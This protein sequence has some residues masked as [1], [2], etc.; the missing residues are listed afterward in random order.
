MSVVL[1]A[2]TAKGAAILTSDAGRRNWQRRFELKGWNVTASARDDQGRYYVAVTGPVFGPALFF[3]DDLENWTQLEAAPR[4]EPGNKANALHRR[5]TAGAVDPMGEGDDEARR[6]EQIWTL[7]AANGKLYAGVSEAGL[8][9]SE[10]RGRSWEPVRGLN[11]HESREHWM[12]GA[13]GLCAHTVLTDPANP[14]RMWVGISAAGFFRSDDGGKTWAAKNDGIPES[15]GQCVHCVTHDPARPEV[16]YRQDHRG[17]YR[18]DDG[19][20]NWR[21]IEQG[22]PVSELSDGL[23]CS[24]GFPIAHDRASGSLFVVPLESDQYRTPPGGRLAVYRSRDGGQSW[25]AAAGGLPD[26]C[27]AGVLRGALD[28]DQL[29]PGGVYFGTTSGVVYGSTDLGESWSE[30]TSGLPR[31]G[32]VRAYAV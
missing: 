3:S 21:V 28:A 25:Q 19:G 2:G 31:I 11:E 4:F 29:D 8:F 15:V 7:H 12:P 14:E 27:Y 26:G 24:F 18:S 23:R 5:F 32:S 10:D 30:L 22:L 17:V 9:V 20:D 6:V 13:G 16:L 1:I